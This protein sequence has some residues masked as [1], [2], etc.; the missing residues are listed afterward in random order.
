MGHSF[1]FLVSS[2]VCISALF[3][4]RSTAL[5][6]AVGENTPVIVTLNAASVVFLF[7][8]NR[9]KG[10]SVFLLWIVQ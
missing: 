10:P 4:N 2:F 7:V 5:L 8:E 3:C 6:P 1:C 9:A